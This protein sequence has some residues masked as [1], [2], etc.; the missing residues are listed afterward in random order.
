[1]DMASTWQ[2]YQEEVAA[3]FRSLGLEATTNHTA[4]GARTEHDV[5]VFVRSHQVGF[6][7]VWIV[8]CKH[9]N[10]PVNKLHVLGLR[11][12]VADLGVDRGILLCEKG[13]QSG[14]MEAA[15]LTNVHLCSLAGLRRT[16][17]EEFTAM[18]LRELFDLAD[19]CRVRYW[20]LPKGARV[21]SGLSP[22]LGDNVLYSG[23]VIVEVAS[24]LL[25]KALRGSYPTTLTSMEGYATFGEDR[26]F[27]SA[28]EILAVV[29][30]ML[31][32]LDKRLKKCEE[33]IKRGNLAVCSVCAQ[34]D[35]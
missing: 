34:F 22:D 1:M 31:A 24:D 5:D 10:T 30:P 9:W 6:D 23:N 28:Q 3:F 19:S 2:E 21:D 14:A 25:G 11:Q 4:K 7:V 15:V 12:I 35:S 20:E 27:A 26:A 17:S 29:E 32:E 33:C 16:A 8:E 13:F 18:R